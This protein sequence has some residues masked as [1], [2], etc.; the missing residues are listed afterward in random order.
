MGDAFRTDLVAG[1]RQR[2]LLAEAEQAR[3]FRRVGPPRA[4]L[5]R[6][7][8]DA[9]RNILTLLTVDPRH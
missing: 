6:R 3:L 1:M 7:L 2:E 8:V 4:R 5:A 9:A